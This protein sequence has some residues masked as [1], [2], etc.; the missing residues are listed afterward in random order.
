VHARAPASTPSRSASGG[1]APRSS[2]AANAP[3]SASP[4]PVVSTTATSAGASL[5][6]RPCHSIVAP[7]AP[8]VAHD[9]DA[10]LRAAADR[11]LMLVHHEEIDVAQQLVRQRRRR[12][13]VQMTRA[14]RDFA[15]CARHG[16]LAQ[17]HLQLHQQRI[18]RQERIV[19][20][21]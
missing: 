14:P 21:P 16:H 9:V 3:H 10:G 15:R 17:G 18:A 12:G 20:N 19:G 7:R 11:C 5:Q 1:A 8:S 2:A 13:A 6:R 4:A